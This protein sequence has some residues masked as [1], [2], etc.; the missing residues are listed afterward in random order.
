MRRGE[1]LA[2]TW[3]NV[4]ASKRLLHIP[5]TKTGTPRT[6]PLT[7]GALAVLS[8]EPVCTSPKPFPLTVETINKAWRRIIEW[9]KLDDL[10]L[11]DLR[12]EAI[13]RFFERGLTIPEV[14]L[15][16]GHKDIKMLFRYTTLRAED[17][18][19]K[20]AAVAHKF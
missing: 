14:A 12:R 3:A 13:S 1:V 17:V 4:N 9:S 11:H 2:V 8:T 15:I 16:S 5:I 19:A 20:L 10:H 18:G 6:I 7:P